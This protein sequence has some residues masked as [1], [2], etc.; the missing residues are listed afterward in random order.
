MTVPNKR[1]VAACFGD[2]HI[3]LIEQ[4]VPE[5]KPGTIAVEVQASL[6]SPGTEVG[7]W[8]GLAGKRKSPEADM[9]PRPFGYSNAGIVLEIG[10]GVTRFNPGDRVACVGFGY[11]MH[12][13]TAIVPHNLAVRLPGKVTFTQGSYGMLMATSLHALRRADLN[14][15]EWY[16][17]IGL[18]LVGQLAAQLHRLAGNYVIGWDTIGFRTE[19]ARKWGIDATV[20]V[21]PED[22]VAIT[23]KF[24]G[25][26]GLDGGLIAFGGDASKAVQ[27]LAKCM[28]RSPDGHP[29]GTIVVVGNPSF[30]FGDHEAAGLTNIDIR[31]AGRTGPGYHDA[32]WEFGPAYPPVFMRWTTTTNLDLCMRLLAEGKLDVDTLTTHL[33]PLDQVDEGTSQAMEDPDSML[34]VVFIRGD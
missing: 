22:P 24:T 9:K 18:G 32:A 10:E 8:R 33:I 19:I 31:R 20:T 13:D 17:A 34:G 12:T 27:D 21:G 26:E 3:R 30:A 15:G 25:G 29:T 4:G 7:G 1:K 16:A 23:R 5:L 6:V 14:F 28:K 2:G 11:A